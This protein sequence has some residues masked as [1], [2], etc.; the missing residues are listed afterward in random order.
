MLKFPIT[1]PQ[2]LAALGR[3][4]HGSK[5]LIA[6]GN[7]PF[8]TK[9]G[10]KAELVCLNLRPGMVTVTDVLEVL[11]QCVQVES[12]AVMQPAKTGPYAVKAD[13]DIFKAFVEIL[14]PHQ[15]S[16]KPIKLQRLERFKFYDAA[17]APDV[18]LTIATGE[19]RIFGNLL[20]TIGV[21]RSVN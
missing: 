3:A 11:A 21:V 4:G 5:I 10:P 9:L 1:H 8:S 12:A 15:P 16:G 17:S 13:P 20:L 19:Q 2:I 18:C 7:Y 6:D 14:T